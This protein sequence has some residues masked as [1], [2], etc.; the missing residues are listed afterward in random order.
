[1]SPCSLVHGLPDL[2]LDRRGIRSAHWKPFLDLETLRRGRRHF[3]PTY[4]RYSILT[5]LLTY[6]FTSISRI[7]NNSNGTYEEYPVLSLFP[8]HPFMTPDNLLGLPYGLLTPSRVYKVGTKVPSPTRSL[9]HHSR[10]PSLSIRHNFSFVSLLQSR[11]LHAVGS[12]TR[13]SQRRSPSRP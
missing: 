5:S 10:T 7:Q 12:R 9:T 1:M 2:S 4:S 8:L 3:Y 11:V 6:S 13:L